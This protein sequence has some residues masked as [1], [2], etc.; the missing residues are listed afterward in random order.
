[1]MPSLRAFRAGLPE[2]TVLVNKVAGQIAY[3]QLNK[4]FDSYR[5]HYKQPDG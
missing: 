2:Q 1:M 4:A 5:D 3:F